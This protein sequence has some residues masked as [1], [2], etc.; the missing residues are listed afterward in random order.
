MAKTYTVVFDDQ[1]VRQYPFNDQGFSDACNHA[2]NYGYEVWE[3]FDG[4][5]RYLMQR[6]RGEQK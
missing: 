1:V 4:D 2:H 3:S 6:P 5:I